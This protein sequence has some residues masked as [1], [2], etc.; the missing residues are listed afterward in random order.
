MATWTPPKAR[1]AGG[2]TTVACKLV[3]FA[4]LEQANVSDLLSYVTFPTVEEESAGFV[5]TL[6]AYVMKDRGKGISSTVA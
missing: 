6:V 1:C 5:H 3:P 4:I 2:G